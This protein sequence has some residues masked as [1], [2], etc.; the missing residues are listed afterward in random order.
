ML[1]T[2]PS[3]VVDQP[4]SQLLLTMRR[5]TLH[6]CQPLTSEWPLSPSSD[7]LVP[8]TAT[9]SKDG[10]SSRGNLLGPAYLHHGSNWPRVYL[11]IP[12]AQLKKPPNTNPCTVCGP[13]QVV[14]W[15]MRTRQ[16]SYGVIGPP[17]TNRHNKR[18]C[19]LAISRSRSRIHHLCI[20]V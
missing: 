3:S 8:R 9:T 2:H 5:R 14:F 1:C 4:V 18:R 10:L 11:S 6:S 17:F 16:H 12:T 20:N 19:D 13:V 15:S 7:P